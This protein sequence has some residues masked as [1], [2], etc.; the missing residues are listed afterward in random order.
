[1]NIQISELTSHDH[2]LWADMFEDYFGDDLGE[3]LSPQVIRE[4]LCPFILQQQQKGLLHIALLKVQESAAGF[5]IYQ[6]DSPESDWCK[7]PGE[8]CIREFFIRKEFRRKGLGRKLCREALC[9]LEKMGAKK[10]Y[11][12]ADEAAGFWES[13]GFSNTGEL[14]SNGQN[15]FEL[16]L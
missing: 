15:Y 11:L 10:V 12:T 7:R 4:K 14:C 6:I 8:G 2:S 16:S 9:E 13:C 1:M 5:C 3:E